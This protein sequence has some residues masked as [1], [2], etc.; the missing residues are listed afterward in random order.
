MNTRLLILPNF[1]QPLNPLDYWFKEVS[2]MLKRAKASNLHDLNMVL[3]K[4]VGTD[5]GKYIREAEKYVNK[6]LKKEDF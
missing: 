3:Q 6:G 2:L 1:S 5:F 4:F